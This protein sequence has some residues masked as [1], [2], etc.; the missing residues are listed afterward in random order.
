MIRTH[1][2]RRALLIVLGVLLLVPVVLV[3]ALVLVLRSDSGT[4]WVIDQVE[5][6][7]VEQG[8]G[9]LMGVWQA[10]RL[11]WQGFGVELT[12]QSPYLDWSPGC[13]LRRS[14]CIEHLLAADIDLRILPGD[15]SAEASTA[16]SLPALDLPVNLEL[17]NVELGELRYNDT[18]VWN[19]F[20]LSAGGYGTSVELKKLYVNRD[21]I[22][23]TASGHLETRR[24]WP[25]SLEVTAQLPPPEGD[26]WTLDLALTGSVRDLNLQG[27]S[28]G[29]LD[30]GL[31]GHLE[32]LDP[33]LPARLSLTADQFKVINAVPDTVT[34][35]NWLLKADGNLTSGFRIDSQ[36]E[37]PARSG[38][39]KLSVNALV[40][41]SDARDVSVEL[42]APYS[43]AGEAGHAKM[44]GS[45][46][47]RDALTADT[48]LQMEK[49][50]WYDLLPGL[51]PPPV[52]LASLDVKG[53]Y[54]DGRYQAELSASA[55]SPAGDIGVTT[56]V[57]GDL[58]RVSITDL[59]VTTGAGKLTGKANAA[60]KDQVSWDASLTLNDFNPGFWVPR[61]EASLD[62]DVSSTGRLNAQGQPDLKAYWDLT[63]QWRKQDTSIQGQLAGRNGQ[64]SVSKLSVNVGDNQIQGS[65]ELGQSLAASMHVALM[66]LSQVLPGL[67]GKISGDAK[68]GG[69][70]D[71]PTGQVHLT[72][73]G[74]RWKDTAAVDSLTLDASLADVLK[75]KARLRAS[76]IS[77]GGQSFES[78]SIALRGTPA[79]H[80]LELKASNPQ[81]TA[82]LQFD[83]G[84]Q[85]GWQ[86]T[87]TTG[88][89]D[90]PEQKQAWKLAEPARIS[91]QPTGELTFKKHC[92]RW[93]GSSLCAGDQSLMPRL[94]LNY[95]I[96]ALPA[97]ALAP[98]LP[99]SVR[100]Q[101]EINGELA[102]TLQ[103]QGPSG[104]ISLSAAPG[105]VRLKS[106]DNWQTLSY[107]TL[108]T[109]VTLKPDRADLKLTLAGQGLG[110]LSVAMKV[111]PRSDAYRVDG[112]YQLS[113]LD[114]ALAG[115]FIALKEIAGDLGGEGTF[116]GPLLDPRVEGELKLDQGRVMDP[117]L[118]LPFEDVS[119]N[120]VFQGHQAELKGR[121]KS[122]KQGSGKITGRIGWE[123][124]PSLKIQVTG[125]KLPLSY[126]PY[127]HVELNPDIT[128]VFADGKLAVNGKVDVPRGSVVVRELPKQAVS[129]SDDEVI[130]GKKK[131]QPGLT[132]LTM[133][134]TVN[135]GKDQ[136][137]FKGFGVTGNLDGSLR[138]GNNMD[139][140]GAL[141]LKDGSYSAYGQDLTLRRARVVFVGPISQPYLDIEAIRKVNSVTAGIR[142]TGPV[143]EPET[144]VF[145]EPPMQ[146]SEALSY[147]I[148]GRPLRSS[149]DQNQ[150]GQAALS[151]GLAQTGGLTR[152]IG[153][154]L[155]I[156]DLTLEAAGSGKSA[157]VVASGYVTDDLSVRYGVGVFEP[158]TTV[159]LRYDL[160]KYFY[161][162][163]ASSLAASLDVF[164]T[165][166]F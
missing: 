118:P 80:R 22:T 166:D 158:I 20:N 147:V 59:L 19:T 129:V 91:Y 39:M 140:R 4:A 132:S 58:S 56:R 164:Y 53:Q 21:T 142:L 144:E 99:E 100:W 120:L 95:R 128:L 35:K 153:K 157:S 87:L 5:G 137:T 110:N 117:S 26:R 103:D 159:A 68:A 133:D 89:I 73:A 61:L 40:S 76:G 98:L 62:G 46:D 121:W 49:F 92:W 148:L 72:G 42:K 77:A 146:Q 112:R 38:R 102:L 33:D 94:A 34:L 86:G 75:L 17:G 55:D 134:V 135:V 143:S 161:L 63:G 93:R 47:W 97:S 65:A 30:A 136:V 150:L 14:V 108:Q 114:V 113:H 83:G 10:K 11:R 109:D 69:T 104:H 131:E 90:L 25:L 163:A 2:F 32:P 154:E 123:N 45:I 160:G 12:V 122:G 23:V 70:L 126:E 88:E 37:L 124:S 82:E 139:T 50:P 105:E 43:A 48:E 162:E 138:I 18:L 52:T 127:A 31:E 7:T 151:L 29:Y 78:A 101:T 28:A 67:S 84:W 36:A 79:D 145:S 107:S 152:G 9:S 13:L 3:T 15:A 51:T 119:L 85:Q 149:G 116:S 125:D 66:D 74:V 8:A 1:R 71:N 24:D 60:F 64:W 111:D 141:E 16:P 41:A 130:V 115:K 106:G 165:R 6:L 27:R 155:G 44:T 96:K 156:R 54:T 81:V 57:D